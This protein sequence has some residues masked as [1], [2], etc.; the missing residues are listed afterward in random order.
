MKKLLAF[1]F[2]AFFASL[3]HL[4]A[5]KYP[6]RNNIKTIHITSTTGEILLLHTQEEI[7]C[8]YNSVIYNSQ[9]KKNITTNILENGSIMLSVTINQE[10]MVQVQECSNT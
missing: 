1:C 7:N 4:E 5:K 2:L 9:I 6:C 8:F 10:N 3:A